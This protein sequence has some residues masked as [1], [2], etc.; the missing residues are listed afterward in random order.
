MTIL[1]IFWSGPDTELRSGHSQRRDGNASESSQKQTPR[2]RSESAGVAGVEPFRFA[3]RALNW[4][5][6]ALDPSHP[7]LV[8]DCPNSG[9]VT[10]FEVSRTRR[11]GHGPLSNEL[12]HFPVR[13]PSRG[14]RSGLRSAHRWRRDGTGHI[15]AGHVGIG[16]RS[17][18]GCD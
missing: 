13:T 12:T 9:P 4:G 6:A 1:P 11:S 16:A 8:L 7:S 10:N 17:G 15:A 14:N 2:T 5:L 3:P 18:S